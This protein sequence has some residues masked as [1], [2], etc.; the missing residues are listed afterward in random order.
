MQVTK[1]R[2]TKEIITGVADDDSL[3]D[4]VRF[5]LGT[6]RLTVGVFDAHPISIIIVSKTHND[7]LTYLSTRLIIQNQVRSNKTSEL[8]RGVFC[9]FIDLLYYEPY[10]AQV[11]KETPLHSPQRG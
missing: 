6:L 10:I 2:T 11:T 7:D 5:G 1:P 8:I 4:S 3:D 9:C